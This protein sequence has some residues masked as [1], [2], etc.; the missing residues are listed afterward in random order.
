MTARNVNTLLPV[1]RSV[2]DGLPATL[3]TRT[4]PARCPCPL[5]GTG[6]LAALATAR[7]AGRLR[8][9]A[10]ARQA[11]RDL[12]PALSEAAPGPAGALV[13]RAKAHTVRLALLYALTEGARAIGVACLAAQ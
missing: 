7:I 12:N 3:P 8:F 5:A 13:A 9:S 6:L 1:L 2:W 10:A 4:A 11:W